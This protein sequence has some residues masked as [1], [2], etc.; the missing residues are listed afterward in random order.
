MPSD[1]QMDGFLPVALGITG[2]IGTW[3]LCVID[4]HS[5]K[6]LSLTFSKNHK[7]KERL[8]PWKRLAFIPAGVSPD[9]GTA[10]QRSM[11]SGN[12]LLVEDEGLI[13][14]HLMEVLTNAGYSV[15]DLITSGEELLALLEHT[16]RPDAI[17]MDIGLAGKI[18]G[19]ETARRLRDR[20][21]IRVIFLT[22]YSDQN[23]L[24]EANEV[25]P[26][27]YLVKPVMQED[28]LRAVGKSIASGNN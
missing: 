21:N 14:L 10:W 20:Y 24:E 26:Y 18:D 25:N 19:I 12:I 5:P 7:T 15:T 6:R 9:P 3:V 16:A 11:T 13:A 1:C 27:E 2:A 8:M 28:L 23:R 22:A 4:L 17:I